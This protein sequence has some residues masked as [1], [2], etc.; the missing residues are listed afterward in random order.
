MRR[1]QHR[2]LLERRVTSDQYNTHVGATYK[3][4]RVVEQPD[5]TKYMLQNP[6]ARLFCVCTDAECN[7]HDIPRKNSSG[8]YAFST[9]QRK[10]RVSSWIYRKKKAISY[11]THTNCGPINWQYSTK[12]SSVRTNFSSARKASDILPLGSKPSSMSMPSSPS[13][14][15]LWI[16]RQEK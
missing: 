6:F 16:Y 15:R 9:C 14:Q 7:F 11:A 8:R 3:S 5:A 13:W 12:S 4:K 10:R 2:F 1:S